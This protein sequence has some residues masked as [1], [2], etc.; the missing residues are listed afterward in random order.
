[1]GNE[2]NNVI[3]IGVAEKIHLRRKIEKEKKE[4]SQKKQAERENLLIAYQETTKQCL[5]CGS[6]LCYSEDNN[7]YYCPQCEQVFQDFQGTADWII[8]LPQ[9]D[10]KCPVCKSLLHFM[11][12]HE[13]GMYLCHECFEKSIELEKSSYFVCVRCNSPININ[14]EESLENCPEC[15][16]LFKKSA[17]P[18]CNQ[19]IWVDDQECGHCHRKF[20]MVTCQVCQAKVHM[21]TDQLCPICE[22]YLGEE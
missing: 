2:G 12:E 18:T 6:N 14:P 22:C 3:N 20:K 4:E 5:D 17:C 8:N 13:D 10:K 21:T 1:M 16:K 7:A 11:E 9:T 15:H 19:Q